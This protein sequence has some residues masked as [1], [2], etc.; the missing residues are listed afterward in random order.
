MSSGLASDRFRRSL[1]IAEIALS[2]VLVTTGALLARSFHDL[3][4]VPVGFDPEHLVSAQTWLPTT[5]YPDSLSQLAFNARLTAALQQDFGPKAVTLTSSLPVE[6]GTSG[7]VDIEGRQFPNGDSPMVEKRVVGNEYFDVMRAKF[8]DGRGLRVGDVLSAT[9]VAV[10][11]QAFAK[12][13]F[14]QQSPVGHRLM[15]GWGTDATET[16]VGVVADVREGPVDEAP[17]PTVYVSA[18]Q[19]PNTFMNAVIRTNHSP[20][21]VE[22]A[23]RRAL[24]SIDPLLP[25]MDVRPVSDVIASSVRQRRL[26]ATILASFAA[27]ALLL[28]AIG[29]YGVVNYAVAQRTQEFGIRAAIGA[30]TG[31]LV[32]RQTATLIVVGVVIGIVLS[33]GSRRLIEAQLFGVSAGDPAEFVFTAALMVVIGLVASAVPTLKA[34]RTGPLEALRSVT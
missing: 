9:P 8:A 14:A 26:V 25:V 3:V 22:R 1:I 19:V 23:Y 10:V 15:F 6:G 24:R 4:S 29:L 27:S 34:A 5:R 33:V 17:R 32:R 21:D 13:W 7:S 16:I 30:Q 12:R 18:S 31:D 2:F 20:A 28:A 11:N